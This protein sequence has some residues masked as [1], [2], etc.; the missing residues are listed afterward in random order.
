MPL[1]CYYS[2]L[3]PPLSVLIPLPPWPYL[4]SLCVSVSLPTP[5]HI[6]FSDF[7]PLKTGFHWSFGACPVFNSCRSVT[8][9]LLDIFYFWLIERI[10]KKNTWKLYMQYYR[11]EISSSRVKI[12]I[13]KNFV[14]SE[15]DLFPKYL[16]HKHKDLNLIP[17]IHIEEAWKSGMS[18]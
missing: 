8:L 15:G 11:K 2:A 18:L 7:P 5:S 14:G 3:S 4:V 12:Y 10:C 9:L 17:R 13:R 1:L 6:L 16:P